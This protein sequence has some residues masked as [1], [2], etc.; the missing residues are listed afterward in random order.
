MKTVNKFFLSNRL[1]IEIERFL[2]SS[3]WQSGDWDSWDLGSIFRE[4]FF[5]DK[6]FSFETQRVICQQL[7]YNDSILGSIW[8]RIA[9]K[10]RPRWFRDDEFHC[11]G[12]ETDIRDC[13]PSPKPQLTRLGSSSAKDLGVVCKPNV[14]QISGEF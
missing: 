10:L 1:Q 12:N 3:C 14:P 8:M 4:H 9:P 11:L 5:R 13:I 2:S 7:G 6:R